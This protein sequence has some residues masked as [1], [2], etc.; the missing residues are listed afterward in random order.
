MVNGFDSNDDETC[1]GRL[2]GEPS[3]KMIAGKKTFGDERLYAVRMT[4]SSN[5]D[6]ARKLI[7][8]NK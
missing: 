1:S 3:K 6:S 8:G 2:G 5:L 4:R 7:I